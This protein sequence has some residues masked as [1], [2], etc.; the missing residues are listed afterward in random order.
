MKTSDIDTTGPKIHTTGAFLET[1]RRFSG[2]AFLHL[3]TISGHLYPK[4]LN[5]QLVTGGSFVNPDIGCMKPTWKTEATD[6][7]PGGDRRSSLGRSGSWDLQ[8]EIA[9][10][11]GIGYSDRISRGGSSG[12]LGG[13]VDV[14]VK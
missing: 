4:S 12:S 2:P 1:S 13:S 7:G 10:I 3:R 6:G 9:S 5:I 14:P 11:T 8:S